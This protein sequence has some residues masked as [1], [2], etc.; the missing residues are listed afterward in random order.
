M[1]DEFRKQIINKIHEEIEEKNSLDSK[2]Q[3]VEALKQDSTVKKYLELLREI[4]RIKENLKK[5]EDIYHNFD[6][7]IE[8]RIQKV[9]NHEILISRLDKKCNCEHNIWIYSGSYY[10][11]TDFEGGAIKARHYKE[12]VPY[13][14]LNSVFKYN[15]YKCLECG[16]VV[17][18][19]DGEWQKFEHTNCVL[20]INDYID[21]NYYQYLYFKLLYEGYDIED[22]EKAVIEEF[23]NREEDITLKRKKEN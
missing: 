6:D 12:D 10:H 13:N 18:K 1:T 2:Y 23:V 8:K 22:A 16:E 5:Y 3:E 15:E 19:T 17:K 20:K 7:S 21:F 4:K 9:F 14:Y 11:E